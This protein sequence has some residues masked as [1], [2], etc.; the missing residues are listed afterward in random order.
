MPTKFEQINALADALP[1]TWFVVHA[2]GR[3]YMLF[4]PGRATIYF[5]YEG[6][7]RANCLSS[8]LEFVETVDNY[9]ISGSTTDMALARSVVHRLDML[10]RAPT[11]C[12][13]INLR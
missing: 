12:A 3:S 2:V 9:E 13:D 6:H 10:M 7:A 5:D 4:C 11:V 8:R 1:G